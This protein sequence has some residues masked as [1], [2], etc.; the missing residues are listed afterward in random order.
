MRN[1]ELTLFDSGKYSFSV[2]HQANVCSQWTMSDSNL[3]EAGKGTAWSL[4]A[5]ILEQDGYLFLVASCY[6]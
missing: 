6:Y 4:G 5:Q 1:Q 3:P 2:P